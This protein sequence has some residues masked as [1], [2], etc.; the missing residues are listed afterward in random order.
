MQVNSN[1]NNKYYYYYYYLC[2][3]LYPIL[4]GKFR[5]EKDKNGEATQ[6]LAYKREIK[7]LTPP[8]K[9]KPFCLEFLSKCLCAN[10]SCFVCYLICLFLSIWLCSDEWLCSIILSILSFCWDYI[11][12][13]FVVPN[14]VQNFKC[15]STF[16]VR[17][18]TLQIISS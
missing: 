8:T 9:K 7:I 2:L 10:D 18:S 15:S 1:Y 13:L 16:P 17:L 5:K 14:R 12:L 11:K 3:C 6:F 4:N